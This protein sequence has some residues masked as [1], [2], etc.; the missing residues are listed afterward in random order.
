MS[1]KTKSAKIFIDGIAIGS[2]AEDIDM[3]LTKKGYNSI[4]SQEMRHRSGEDVKLGQVWDGDEEGF[5]IVTGI[6]RKYLYSVGEWLVHV[7]GDIVCDD[8]RIIGHRLG[9][10]AMIAQWPTLFLNHVS[11]SHLWGSFYSSLPK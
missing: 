2:A 9:A 10:A 3:G 11:E 6:E 4:A 8:E 7:T 5:F 1:Q